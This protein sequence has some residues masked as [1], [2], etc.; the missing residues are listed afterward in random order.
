MEPQYKCL[1]LYQESIILWTL[2][3]MYLSM[4]ILSFNLISYIAPAVTRCLIAMPDVL[5]TP[6]YYQG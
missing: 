4:S 3:F 5:F 1:Q 2:A 6:I